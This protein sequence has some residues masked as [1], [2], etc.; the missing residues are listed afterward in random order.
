MKFRKIQECLYYAPLYWMWY[1]NWMN[2]CLLGN[3]LLT[4]T[5]FYGECILGCSLIM[6]RTLI[7]FKLRIDSMHT[8]TLLS[9]YRV[10]LTL[11]P[12]STGLYTI[13]VCAQFEFLSHLLFLFSAA[14]I[15]IQWKQNC[16]IVAIA[17]NENLKQV[18]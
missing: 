18:F 6:L 11:L 1:L 4:T 14:K 5:V 3:G 9:N 8:F 12:S 10:D 15:L 7:L 17:L 2:L 13:N 16:C